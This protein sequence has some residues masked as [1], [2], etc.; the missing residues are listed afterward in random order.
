MVLRPQC[1]LRPI[2]L[3][4]R[5]FLPFLFVFLHVRWAVSECNKVDA[6]NKMRA[7]SRGEQRLRESEPN[8]P[9]SA[10]VRLAKELARVRR[11][12]DDERYEDACL[13]YDAL[14]VKYRVDLDEEM[15]GLVRYEDL[16]QGKAAGSAC[17]ISGIRSE[18]AA[19]EQQMRDRALVGEIPR[20]KAERFREAASAI[21]AGAIE[22]PARACAGLEVMKKKYASREP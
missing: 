4:W 14:A 1:V 11:V 9:N 5:W 8:S 10:A 17:S 7:L 6:F 18:L 19:L 15:K 12:L 2:S 13:I 3:R 22:N 16:P 21:R 20:E